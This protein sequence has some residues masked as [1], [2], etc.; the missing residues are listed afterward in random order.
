MT[1]RDIALFDRIAEDYD[2]VLPFFDAF[3]RNTLDALPLLPGRRVLDLGAGH[4]ALTAHALPRGCRVTAVDAAPAMV[5]RLRAE[6]TDHGGFEGAHLMDA[7]RLDL[8]DAC[9]DTVLSGFVLH[10]VDEPGRA[11]AEIGRVLAP[12]GLLAFT[13]P[14]TAPGERPPPPDPLGELLEEY[15]AHLMPG[16]GMGNPLMLPDELH[17]AGFTDI[18]ART[19]S[20][21]LP[22]PDGDVLWRWMLTH[23]YRSF[24]EGL[25]SPHREE[26]RTRLV[27]AV[28]A[29]P[30]RLH[31]TAALWT[32]CSGR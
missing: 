19:I 14:G 9:F 12:D 15:R 18:R 5:E 16:G 11:L 27:A 22:V 26:F 2:R 13:V 29:A 4:G 1:A 6:R 3:A 32:C 23:G 25:P 7:H 20:V 21:D 17:G 30:F 8:P 24:L 31:R 10:L 28:D